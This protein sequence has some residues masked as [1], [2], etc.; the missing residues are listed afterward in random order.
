MPVDLDRLKGYRERLGHQRSAQR[1]RQ[2]A[3]EEFDQLWRHGYM[4]RDQAYRWLAGEMGRD[5]VHM[6]W[7]DEQECERVICLV[8]DLLRDLHG[9]PR[10]DEDADRGFQ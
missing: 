2:R 6:A 4:S 8:D 10:K 7:M 1:A 5:E 3:H 9:L